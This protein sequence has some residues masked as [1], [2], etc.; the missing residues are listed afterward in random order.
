MKQ[1][2]LSRSPQDKLAL[3]VTSSAVVVLLLY[4]LLWIPFKQ[5]VD[6]KGVLVDS[7]RSTLKWM[8]ES[9]AKIKLIKQRQSSSD[10][11]GRSEA[12]LTLVDRTA[13]KNQL[14][15]FIQRLKP[16]GSSAVQI[17]VE[18]APFDSL[19]QWLG[20]L[21]NQYGILLESVNIERQDKPGVINAKLNLQ[22][23]A[24]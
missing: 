3:M 24:L 10:R 21:V 4:L 8:Q 2:W 12:L 1:W 6:K 17:W 9:A 20:L 22:R 23:E 16:D 13:K 15:Q 19:I 14:R 7:Q 18:Q 5:Q 11:S